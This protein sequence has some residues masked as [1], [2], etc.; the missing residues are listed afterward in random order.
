MPSVVA[1]RPAPGII[2]IAVALGA[3]AVVWLEFRRGLAKARIIPAEDP[4]VKESL[5]YH[6]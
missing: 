1:D 4:F 2:E 3:A 5:T 6:G